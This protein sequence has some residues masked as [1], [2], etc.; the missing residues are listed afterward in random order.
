MTGESWRTVEELQAAGVLLVEDGNHGEYRPRLDEFVDDGTAFIRAADISDG[1]VD[2][3]DCE[4]INDVAFARIR[5]GIGR[6]NDILLSHKGTVGKLA[7]VPDDAPPF[8]CSPQT[9]FWR[10]LDN[11]QLDRGYLYAFMRSGLFKAQLAAVQGETDM[12]PYVSL[13]AQRRLKIALP[14]IKHQIAVGGLLT[15]L[16]DKIA[17]N[18]R[19]NDT[20]EAMARAFFKSWFVDFDAVRA[21][22]EGR[23]TGLASDVA[24]LFPGLMDDAEENNLPVGW[25]YAS[26]SEVTSEL[27][28]GIAPKYVE[29]GGVC[30]I[31]QRC[32]RDRKVSLDASRRH[33]IEQRTIDGRELE[34]GDVLVNSTGVGTLGRVGQIWTLTETTVADSHVTVVRAGGISKTYLGQNLRFREAEI[35]ALGEG[36]T[37]QT[38]LSRARLGELPILVPSSPILDAFDEIAEPILNRIVA[39]D[40][41]IRTLASLRDL[42]L[43]KLMSGELQIK[44]AERLVGKSGA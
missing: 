16:D 38:E 35:E 24:V 28:R 13:T 30:V 25:R 23:E 12:A 9:T 31:N 3:S 27:R 18:R 2:F 6:P 36:S 14:S 8:V 19:M 4:H 37:G 17:L 34:V 21:K 39:N 26:L 44:D 1:R 10:V 5:K 7:N 32:I 22:M 40:E 20:L 42:L 43:P 33:D 29:Q 15:T 11:G 41:G